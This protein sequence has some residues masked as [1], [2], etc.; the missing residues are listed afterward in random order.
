MKKFLS[1]VLCIV[2][3][4]S[5]VTGIVF[6]D[7]E[8]EAVTNADKQEELR[9]SIREDV[10]LLTKTG[11]VELSEQYDP[12][13]VVTRAEFADYAAAA[14]KASGEKKM[15]YFSDVPLSHWAV[16]SINALVEMKIIDRADDGKFNPEEPITYPQACKILAAMTG[17]KAYAD[18]DKIMDEYVSVARKAG[19]GIN[20]ASYD[21]VTIAEAVQL[22]YN[23]MRTDLTT[24][25]S[26]GD[27]SYTVQLQ[28]GDN[29]FSVYH[30]IKFTDG[31]VQ[32]V[33]GKTINSMRAESGEAYI[34]GERYNVDSDVDIDEFFGRYINFAYSEVKDARNTKTVIYAEARYEKDVTKILYDDIKGYNEGTKTLSYYDGLNKEK[35]RTKTANS[36]AYIVLNGQPYDKGIKSEI[37]RLIDGTRKGDVTY[38]SADGSSTCDLIIVTSYEIFET[39][40]YI[41]GDKKFYSS[42]KT[43]TVCIDDYQNCY[44]FDTSG[45]AFDISSLSTGPYMIAASDNKESITI[46]VCT[47]KA[48]GTLS[49]V[50]PTERI[51]TIGDEE[52]KADKAFYEKNKEALTVGASY[53]I[54]LDMYDE[55]VEYATLAA[56]GMKIG[57]LTKA[58][59]SD[60]VFDKNIRLRIYTRD[61]NTMKDF[62]LA[63][64]VEIDGEMYK[65]E[66]YKDIAGAFPG[67]T[68]VS[69]DKVKLD[70]Q[71]IRYKLN[72]DGCIDKIDTTKVGAAEDKDNTL[73][74]ITNGA[75]D[76]IY[77]S[78]PKRFGMNVYVGSSTSFMSVPNV[79]DDGNI[80]VNGNTMEDT[81]RMYS[82]K[83]TLD[84]WYTYK[85]EAFKYSSNVLT[86]E[87]II[88]YLD[89]KESNYNVIMYEDVVMGL[90]AD[91]DVVRKLAGK[92]M[93][94]DTE[95]QLD[96]MVD[97]ATLNNLKKGD[98]VRVENDLTGE[99]AYSVTKMYDAETNLFENN[100]T[101]TDPERYWYGGT[102]SENNAGVWRGQK[103]Q[104]TRAYAY[105]VKGNI[106]TSSYTIPMARE[107]IV[108]EM[109][110]CSKITV[111]VYDKNSERNP[112]YKGSTQDILTYKTAGTGCDILILSSFNSTLKQ[113]FVIK[114]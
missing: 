23:A 84:D 41:S 61:D 109:S 74:S 1:C 88:V 59:L 93:G 5:S 111:T 40:S 83:V 42:D 14:I 47:Q 38:I 77:S 87:L 62:E 6:A 51:Y 75:K 54:W 49:A 33:F 72:N 31:R 52:Y 113:L 22:I 71:V 79:D 106:V 63:S 35:V 39:E 70:R 90:D 76:V 103:Y 34:G 69:N 57:Y 45:I 26:V 20:T 89:P 114:Q 25:A 102:Y 18:M 27:D 13:T 65:A 50:N 80:V 107:D 92:S 9:N 108:S 44:I 29:I 7:N 97:E 98:I 30:N 17:Y 43:N 100:E 2:M 28:K 16:G 81:A 110:D 24:I 15:T 46:V 55:I 21:Q 112:I 3:A 86:P 8:S 96:E 36:N 104:L 48:E 10:Y 91:G 85:I 66:N 105:D 94:Q 64:K 68:E 78:T 58:A 60:N 101:W 67:K 73:H 32:S 37:D 19:F 11:V 82:D 99:K 56:D 53:R 4:L 12:T 95:I